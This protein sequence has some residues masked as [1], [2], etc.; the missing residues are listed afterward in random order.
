MRRPDVDGKTN[1]NN[2]N[3]SQLYYRMATSG[4]RP[5]GDAVPVYG[6][7]L[8]KTPSGCTSTTGGMIRPWA[9]S[10]QPDPIVPQPGNPQAARSV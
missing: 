4:A 10:S 8:E 3:L 5:S 1:D 9:A 6:T 7:A 2:A